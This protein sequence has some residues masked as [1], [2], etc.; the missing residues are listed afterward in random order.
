[1]DEIY[2]KALD[3]IA[4]I[5]SRIGRAYNEGTTK[6]FE[7]KEASQVLEKLLDQLQD[8]EN[9]LNYYS[10]SYKEG[11]LNESSNGKFAV[12]Y[13]KGGESYPLS[14][15]SSLEAYLQE[16]KENGIEQGWHSGRVEHNGKG[17]YFYGPGKP[18]LYTG[19][20]VRLRGKNNI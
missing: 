1:M 5:K 13:D 7:D 8:A 6:T 3:D 9:D 2:L 10:L 4:Y 19:M 12:L 11:R 18:M 20:R 15:G 17:Y 14:C 16:D